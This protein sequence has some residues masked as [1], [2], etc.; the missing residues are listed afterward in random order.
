M[1]RCSERSFHAA[2]YYDSQMLKSCMSSRWL[3]RANEIA[4]AQGVI[5]RRAVSFHGVEMVMIGRKQWCRC[6]R[7]PSRG[8]LAVR[9]AG[10][11]TR[12]ISRAWSRDKWSSSSLL[13][14][15][16]REYMCARALVRMSRGGRVSEGMV[17][18]NE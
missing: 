13:P 7:A 11:Q 6:C 10:G 17:D 12:R 4:V 8:D 15:G 14:V 5:R 9:N 1:R 16:L 18:A 3:C 2:G